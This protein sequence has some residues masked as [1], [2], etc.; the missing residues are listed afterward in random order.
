MSSAKRV[1]VA[2]L[3]AVLML[4][5][6]APPAFAAGSANLWPN[7]A[8]GNRANTEWRTDS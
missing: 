4:V 8:P 2:A 7:G 1:L 3:F 6:A 5:A